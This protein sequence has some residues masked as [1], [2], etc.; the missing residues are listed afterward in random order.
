M[1]KIPH[2]WITCKFFVEKFFLK[3]MN[4]IAETSS[5]S[6][7]RHRTPTRSPFTITFLVSNIWNLVLVFTRPVYH[8]SCTSVSCINYQ[9]NIM[10]TLLSYSK[11]FVFGFFQ[12]LSALFFILLGLSTLIAKSLY[13]IFNDLMFMRIMV[14]VLFLALLGVI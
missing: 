14:G 4:Y 7:T 11:T 8:G 2:V 5:P 3:N 10:N 1:L 12:G 13:P 9:E 6:I